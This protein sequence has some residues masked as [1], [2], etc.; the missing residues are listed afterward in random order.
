MVGLVNTA[1]T[2]VKTANPGCSAEDKLL[3]AIMY[4]RQVLDM[5]VNDSRERGTLKIIDT[6]YQDL[7]VHKSIPKLP[8]EGLEQVKALALYLPAIS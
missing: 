1:V 6:S 2:R 4:R 3:G 7:Y 8:L 5:N